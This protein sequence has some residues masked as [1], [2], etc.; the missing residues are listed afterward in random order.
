MF[1]LTL[2]AWVGRMHFVASVG[3]VA[4]FLIAVCTSIFYGFFLW[5]LYLALEPFVRRYWP[6]TLIG[7]TN[8]LSGNARDPVV[9]RDVLLGVL[10]GV[11]LTLVTRLSNLR[12]G[13]PVTAAT[14][15]LSG[16]RGAFGLL[17]TLVPYGVRNAFMF[18]FL[19]FLCRLLLRNQWLA[20]AAWVLIFGGINS[21]NSSDLIFSLPLN[22]LF[23]ALSAFFVLRWGLLAMITGNVVALVLTNTPVAWHPSA[24]YF[25][26]IVVLSAVPIVLAA[27]GFRASFGGR[28][29]WKHDLF[30]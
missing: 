27:W 30:G 11:I 1:C 16:T 3:T 10:L 5:T 12:G 18:F 4:M 14:E 24:W 19:L 6:R 22:F 29:L 8:L 28:N 13:D 7:C 17:F 25:G 2:L 26:N 9:G 20:A 15:L 21:L 23:Y